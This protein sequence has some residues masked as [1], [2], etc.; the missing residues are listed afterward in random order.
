VVEHSLPAP[1]S[2][3]QDQES[4][5]KASL[6]LSNYWSK[7]KSESWADIPSSHKKVSETLRE[8]YVARGFRDM[9]EM[10]GAEEI[11]GQE[12]IKG[13][14][15]NRNDLSLVEKWLQ[16]LGLGGKLEGVLGADWK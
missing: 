6:A 5:Q 7:I 11:G 2:P 13:E 9:R 14:R 3:Q 16:G 15:N 10:T 4:L 8:E 12:A 1:S